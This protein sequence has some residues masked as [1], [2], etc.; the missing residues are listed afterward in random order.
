MDY[1]SAL[2]II[3]SLVAFAVSSWVAHKVY[4]GKSTEHRLA[5]SICFAFIGINALV[6]L[7]E[8]SFPNVDTVLLMVFLEYLSESIILLTLLIFVLQYVGMGRWVTPKN[9]LIFGIPG[10][11]TLIFNGTNQWHHLFYVTTDIVHSHGF[12]LFSADYGPLF[13]FWMAYFLLVIGTTTALMA[14]AMVDTPLYRRKALW[15]LMGGMIIIMVSGVFYVFSARDDPV[16][17]ILSIGLTLTAVWIFIGERRSEF[18]DLEIIRFRE[19]MVG[20]EDAIVIFN[21][22]M[23]T[24]FANEHGQKILDENIEFLK[25]RAAVLGFSIPI[26]SQ[27]WEMALKQNGAPR[28]Y[29]LSSSDIIRDGKVIGAIL[30]FHDISNRMAMEENVQRANRGLKTLN[31][32]IRHDMR[33]DLTALWG[34]LQLLEMTELNA[35]QKE[36]VRKM[37]DRARSADGHLTFANEQQTIGSTGTVWYDVQELIEGVLSKMSLGDMEVE[38]CL[39]GIRVQADPMISNVFHCLADNTVRHGIEAT[40]ISIHANE[41]KNG[42]SIIW[43]DDGVGVPFE[44]KE[45]IFNRG[46]G[47][48]TGEG[49][50]LACEILSMTDG[51]ISEGGE[52]DKGAKFTIRLPSGRYTWTSPPEPL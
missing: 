6:L 33:N 3:P 44:Y 48:N 25:E 40:R 19:A 35:R 41:T 23:R 50:F 30:V 26:G 4:T 21:S 36:L 29:S 12:Y 22:S 11:F 18:V 34:Y 28:H 1:Y 37:V 52:P 17:D 13:L 31:Q 38:I 7:G 10:I 32:I 9:V 27:K 5:M 42:L 24:T 14:K 45:K 8:K 16:V 39:Q 15:T 46:F 47:Q 51:S 49:L 43:E 20:I 2:I